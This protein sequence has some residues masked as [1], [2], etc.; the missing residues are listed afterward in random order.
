MTH[1]QYLHCVVAS[2]IGQLFHLAVKIRS[3]SV[4]HKKANLQFSLKG[5]IRDDK[6]ALIVD[7]MGSWVLVYLADE[8]LDLDSRIIDKLKSI[9]FFVGF[10]GSYVVMQLLSVAKKNFRSAVDYKTNIADEATGTLNKPTP[11]K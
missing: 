11:T 2:V 10:T 7:L 4:D 1:E 6:W 8:W 5:Y 9:F 3:M